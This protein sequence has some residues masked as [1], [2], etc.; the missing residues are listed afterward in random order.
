MIL[1]L[2]FARRFGRTFLFT[3]AVFAM[4]VTFV[5]LADTLRQF[6]GEGIGLRGIVGLAL[7]GAP[8]S[9]YQIL[10]LIVLIAVIFFFLGLARSSEM[11]VT[12]AAGRSGLRALVAPVAVAAGIGVVGVLV[13]NPVVAA[14]GRLHD[15]RAAAVDGTG[16]VLS[17]GSTGLWLRQGDADGQTVIRAARTDSSGT[18]LD[19]ATFLTFD[20]EGTPLRRISADRAMLQDGAWA[21]EAVKLWPLD[22]EG[23]PEAEAERRETLELPSTLT[24][25]QIRDSFGSPAEIPI[26]DLPA[27]IER[28]REAGFSARRHAVWL[29]MELSQPA[30]LAAMVLIGAAFTMR[31]QRGGRVGLNVLFA[32]LVAFGIYFLRNFAQILGEA[33]DIPAA[34]AAWVPPSAAAGLA[35]GLLLQREDG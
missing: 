4:L 17:L 32:F 5:A 23:N 22:G 20:A 28:L 2:Y 9:L 26:W 21:L 10:P 35:L 29:Q 16:S 13:L 11:V 18:M 7:L 12:R 8:E 19:R 27:F 6:A 30:F 25:A 24:P 15:L 3:F 31:P 33:G 1:D 34:L 14:T